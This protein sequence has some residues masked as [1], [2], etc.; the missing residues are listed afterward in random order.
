MDKRAGA[1]ATKEK[2]KAM[3]FE[4][5][6]HPERRHVSEQSMELFHYDLGYV[7]MKKP[8]KIPKLLL[9]SSQTRP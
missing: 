7:E 3:I 5:I 1:K 6:L 4:G 8:I 2:L 9:G